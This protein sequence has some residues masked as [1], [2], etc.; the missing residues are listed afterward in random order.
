MCP[1]EVTVMFISSFNVWWRFF[2]QWFTERAPLHPSINS[3]RTPSWLHVNYTH[4]E[5]HSLHSNHAWRTTL[6]TYR[7]IN[8]CLGETGISLWSNVFKQ[9][10]SRHRAI[11]T[12]SFIYQCV[13]KVNGPSNT[14][15]LNLKSPIAHTWWEHATRARLCFSY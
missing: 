1:L 7:D 4:G 14:T 5:E 9:I 12:F 8:I 13:C 3:C 10:H 15:R 6:N 2:M 11:N